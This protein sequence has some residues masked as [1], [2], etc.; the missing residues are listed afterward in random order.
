MQKHKIMSATICT[1]S[2]KLYDLIFAFEKWS[3]VIKKKLAFIGYFFCSVAENLKQTQS[4]FWWTSFWHNVIFFFFFPES[5]YVTT[6]CF[7]S[8]HVFAS[9]MQSYAI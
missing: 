8:A 6:T 9:Y 4:F 3:M 2:K 7:K 5:L 1:Y